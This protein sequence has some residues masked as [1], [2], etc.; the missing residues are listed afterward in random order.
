MDKKTETHPCYG[1]IQISKFQGDSRFFASDVQH[2]GGITISISRASLDRNLNHDWIHDKETLVE[3]QMSPLQ[4]AELITTGMNTSGVPC[5]IRRDASGNVEPADF[6]NGIDQFESEYSDTSEESAK[7]VQE[8]MEMV[9][10]SLSGKTVKKADIKAIK[11]RLRFAHQ[12][13]KSNIPYVKTCFGE[14]IARS[15]VEA[16]TS[17]ENFIESKIRHL[18]VKSLEDMSIKKLEE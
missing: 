1:Q 16:K 9:D 6:T 10:K 8:V 11:S 4:F 3:V 12:H 2:R 18:G 5:T 14:H 17:V 15:I 13:I 7:L